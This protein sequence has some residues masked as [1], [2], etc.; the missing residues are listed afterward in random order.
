MAI[1]SVMDRMKTKEEMGTVEKIHVQQATSN[2]GRL[3]FAE[4][5]PE[6]ECEAG[7][8]QMQACDWVQYS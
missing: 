7:R 1:W 5:V 3:T 8:G 6:H 2:N 4:E